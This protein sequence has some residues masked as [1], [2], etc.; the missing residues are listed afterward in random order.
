[1]NLQTHVEHILKVAFRSFYSCSALLPRAVKVGDQEWAKYLYKLETELGRVWNSGKFFRVQVECGVYSARLRGPSR[2]AVPFWSLA[3]MEFPHDQEDTKRQPKMAINCNTPWSF[4]T[5][6]AGHYWLYL[7]MGPKFLAQPSA[8]PCRQSS[9][10]YGWRCWSACWSR[11]P[12]AP[13]WTHSR[14][15]ESLEFFAYEKLWDVHWCSP[16]N[17]GCLGLNLGPRPQTQIQSQQWWCLQASTADDYFVPQLEALS[18]RLGLQEQLGGEPAKKS[19]WVTS[20]NLHRVSF[21]SLAIGCAI[22]SSTSF[23]QKSKFLDKQW[24]TLD[25]TTLSYFI[26]IYYQ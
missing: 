18:E 3:T 7:A 12:A 15:M 16:K 24:S 9:C 23:S 13:W 11:A 14:S 21:Y 25:F 1:M 26:F 8:K 4:W 5:W 2:Q 6:W 10:C 22:R 19:P 17:P 20:P